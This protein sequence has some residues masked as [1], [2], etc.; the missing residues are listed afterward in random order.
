MSIYFRPCLDWLMLNP[1]HAETL[2]FGFE[3]RVLEKVSS[4]MIL[5]VNCHRV[6]N[7]EK[8]WGETVIFPDLKQNAE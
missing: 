7:L 8:Y 6:C 2:S 1:S 5:C 3:F 4:I